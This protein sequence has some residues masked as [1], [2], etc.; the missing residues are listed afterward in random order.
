MNESDKS[1]RD[2]N[3]GAGLVENLSPEQR[4]DFLDR[5]NGILILGN[6]E[7][8]K[9]ITDAQRFSDYHSNDA[10]SL[11]KQFSH[12]AGGIAENVIGDIDRG[13]EK[14]GQKRTELGQ[15][16]NNFK[17]SVQAGVNQLTDDGL[18]FNEFEIKAEDVK[19]HSL[20][21]GQNLR[22]GLPNL[23]EYAQKVGISLTDALGKVNQY[24]F[25]DISLRE[26]AEQ[27]QA[28]KRT[29]VSLREDHVSQGNIAEQFQE[30][31]HK[32]IDVLV[33][34]LQKLI[35]DIIDVRQIRQT[36][37]AEPVSP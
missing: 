21:Y 24:N 12:V 1:E 33:E 35:K 30:N 34:K 2:P 5:L 26:Q 22:D 8:P 9:I 11:E 27:L 31:W 32:N 36:S 28:L 37:Q 4:R 14:I 20:N 3:E 7:I 17:D 25:N 15:V 10:R 16:W 23:T 6:K 13:S 19:K 29:L 18:G